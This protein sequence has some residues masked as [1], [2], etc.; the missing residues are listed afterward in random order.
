LGGVRRLCHSDGKEAC[1]RTAC[2]P[3]L[4][5]PPHALILQQALH[6]LCFLHDLI[7][8]STPHIAPLYITF[9]HFFS[10][11]I[12]PP[13]HTRPHTHTQ[14]RWNTADNPVKTALPANI[15]DEDL[16]DSR[17]LHPQPLSKRTKM[18]YQLARLKF[19]EFTYRQIWQA[20]NKAMLPYSE[21]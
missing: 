1:A 12:I 10:H 14:I 2:L 13:Q 16:D 9:C 5:S 4:P 11:T 19:I 18:S 17:P 8:P 20:N 3:S 7:A 21:V 6:L 15:D